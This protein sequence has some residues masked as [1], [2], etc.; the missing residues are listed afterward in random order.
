M[1]NILCAQSTSQLKSNDTLYDLIFLNAL[2][3]ITDK[4]SASIN[5]IVINNHLRHGIKNLKDSI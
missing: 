5:K 2:T 4:I 1:S 3:K